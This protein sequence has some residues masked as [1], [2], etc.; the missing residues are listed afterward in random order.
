MKVWSFSLRKKYRIL[1]QKSFM[2][3]GSNEK[4]LLH[5]FCSR[6]IKDF[7]SEPIVGDKI[8]ICRPYKTAVGNHSME[9]RNHLGVVQSRTLNNGIDIDIQVHLEKATYQI[10]SETFE[11]GTYDDI[12]NAVSS[13]ITETE[14]FDYDYEDT[15]NRDLDKI[16]EI[17]DTLN[18][19]SVT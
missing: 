7:V 18:K 15:F 13:L 10:K 2:I 12:K 4:T 17:L 3:I 1:F 14:Y 9:N 5:V 11:S 8:D 16:N 6:L 19:K